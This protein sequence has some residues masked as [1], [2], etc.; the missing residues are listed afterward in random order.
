MVQMIFIKNDPVDPD[1][2]PIIDPGI[3]PIYRI[4]QS[5]VWQ[6]LADGWQWDTEPAIT[7][8]PGWEGSQPTPIGTVP[9][10]QPD[11][12][13]YEAAGPGANM[14]TEPQ[15]FAYTIALKR[16]ETGVGNNPKILGLQFSVR[17]ETALADVLRI[18]PD[19]EN[20]PQP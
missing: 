11:L 9:T 13:L 15:Q 8:D 19:I 14:D 6:I 17:A 5:I 18:D 4:D 3:G 20:R 7:F 10:D 2:Q 12:R 16:I 1:L